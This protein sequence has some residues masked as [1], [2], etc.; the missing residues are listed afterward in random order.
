MTI[1]KVLLLQT[2]VEEVLYQLSCAAS[3]IIFSLFVEEVFYQ[4]SCA[5]SDIIFSLFVEEVL[6]Q[7]P[8]Y[9]QAEDYVRGYK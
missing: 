8:F 5:A 3:D 9:K 6:Y 2:S 1:D 4:L 7:L